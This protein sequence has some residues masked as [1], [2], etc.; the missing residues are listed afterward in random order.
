MILSYAWRTR[1]TQCVMEIVLQKDGSHHMALSSP[2]ALLNYARHSSVI[3]KNWKKCD[4]HITSW[5][6]V[7]TERLIVA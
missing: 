6:R 4:V 7:P 1:D 3:P 5:S 2:S